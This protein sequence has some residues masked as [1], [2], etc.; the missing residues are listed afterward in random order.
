MDVSSPTV[1]IAATPADRLARHSAA[2]LADRLAWVVLA[3]LD[4][5]RAHLPRLR[6]RLGR[7]HPRAI[8][9]PAAVA[10]HLGLPRHPRAVVRQ[11]LSL[12]RRLR[13]GGGAARQG[14]AVRSV[15]DPA[16]ARRRD[17]HCRPRHH[18]ADRPPRR[19]PACR[20]PCAR[21][22]RHLPALL[23][24]HVHESEG[25]AVRRGDG[26]VPARPRAPARSIS[27]ALPDHAVHRRA[28][29]RPLDRLAHPGGLRRARS[30]RRAG[31]A[32]RDRSARRRRPRG[33]PRASA[34]SCSL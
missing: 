31:A 9:R 17:R 14:A 26:A 30:D 18:L 34:V 7:L 5:R 19:R 10:L 33:G 11:S 15:R 27:E 1:A 2:R 13:H 8:R 23:R 24:P 21:A 12:R 28:W 4:R 22:A 16:A 3:M 6:A 29:L 25:R 32:V 20:T